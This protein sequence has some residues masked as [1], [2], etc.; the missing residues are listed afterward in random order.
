MPKGGQHRSQPASIVHLAIGRRGLL[1]RPYRGPTPSADQRR[2][3]YEVQRLRDAPWVAK[4]TKHGQRPFVKL[5]PAVG[6]VEIDV[7]VSQAIQAVRDL[8]GIPQFSR[9]VERLVEE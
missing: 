6:L 9:Q 4:L 2:H 5:E 7:P 1:E 3:A 8:A